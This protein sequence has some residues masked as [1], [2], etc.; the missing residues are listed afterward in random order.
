MDAIE[1][2]AALGSS[3]DWIPE[4]GST[5][6]VLVGLQKAFDGSNEALN[7]FERER[8]T[9]EALGRLTQEGLKEHLRAIAPDYHAH[10]R[11]AGIGGGGLTGVI[12]LVGFVALDRDVVGADDDRRR[13]V[14]DQDPLKAR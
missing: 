11:V 14:H 6:Q 12:G 10:V 2:M 9:Q 7:S 13:G 5:D 8:L 3:A 1:Q 4:P